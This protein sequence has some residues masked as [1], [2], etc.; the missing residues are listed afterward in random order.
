VFL[1]AVEQFEQA[2]RWRDDETWQQAVDEINQVRRCAMAVCAE[3]LIR[4]L[5][6]A[7]GVKPDAPDR[8]ED[9]RESDDYATMQDIIDAL[10]GD[11]ETRPEV[12][13]LRRLVNV[14]AG[15]AQAA[16]PDN[17]LDGLPET[18]GIPERIDNIRNALTDETNE[19][20]AFERLTQIRELLRRVD[21]NGAETDTAAGL[22][23]DIKELLQ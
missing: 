10:G 22:L 13:L 8:P 5:R 6:R 11:D 2:Y 16:D 20:T 21:E 3:D 1:G 18:D 23:D 17:D 9:E 15:D 7:R 4:E 12:R 19:T 14:V